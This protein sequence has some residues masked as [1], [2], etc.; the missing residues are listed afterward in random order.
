MVNV[1]D[2]CNT[3]KLVSASAVLLISVCV[4]FASAI[5]GSVENVLV[6][7]ILQFCLLRIFGST[8]EMDKLSFFFLWTKAGLSS[9][10]LNDYLADIED[11]Q[12]FPV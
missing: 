5:D 10:D 4:G 6:S 9:P 11:Y 2:A 8:I 12:Q 7:E 3:V 1:Q